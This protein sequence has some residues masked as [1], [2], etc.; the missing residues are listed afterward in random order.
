MESSL[1]P[2]SPLPASLDT[3]VAQRFGH[4]ELRAGQATALAAI[5]AGQDALVVLPTGGGKSLCYQAPAVWLREQGRG[6]T[7]VVSPLIS[8]M[9]DQVEALQSKGIRAYALHS[10]QDELEQREVEAFMMTGRLDLLYVSPERAVQPRFHAQL[11]QHRPA[12]VAVDEAHCISQWGHDFRPEYLQLGALKRSLLVPV[13]ALTATATPRVRTEIITALGLTTPQVVC[14]R[15]ARPNLAFSVRHLRRD[16]ERITELDT[17]ISPILADHHGG[18]VIIYCATRKKVEAVAKHL[19]VRFDVAYYHAGRSDLRRSQAQRA[20]DENRKRILVA[21]NAFGMGIDHPDVRLIVHFQAPGSLEAYYQEAGR[22]GRDGMKARCVLF[23]GGADVTTQQFLNRKNTSNVKDAEKRAMLL[24]ALVSYSQTQQCR[25]AHIAG[26]FGSP[27]PESCG[28]CDICTH[29]ALP[30]P[31]ATASAA[32]A[33]VLGAEA[34]DVVLHA[35]ANLNRPVGK[36]LLAR[37]LRGSKARALRR[38]RLQELPEHGLLTDMSEADIVATIELLLKDGRLTK[39]GVKYPTLWLPDRPVRPRAPEGAPRKPRKRSVAG[40]PL[41]QA[42]V[43][44]RTRQARKLKWKR[45]MVF[46]NDVIRQLDDL[47]PDSLWALEQIRGLGPAK[48]ERFGPDLLELVRRY[49]EGA[50]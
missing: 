27:E 5:A 30:A 20:F 24:E 47:H 42:L 6:F 25:Q 19:A 1:P 15:F 26:Y 46:T 34:Q 43:S 38:Y 2:V 10:S 36:H 23:F 41:V 29:E 49:S 9:N 12:L 40:S 3:V 21:T 50:S 16:Q 11:L 35:V 17:L 44:Y 39:K 14:G 33:V 45:Y 48:L 18:R 22:A 32:P 4:T 7:L 13:V 8:L 31:K 28:G 37:A